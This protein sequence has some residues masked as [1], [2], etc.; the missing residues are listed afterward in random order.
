M[1]RGNKRFPAWWA[2]CA[3]VVAVL[4]LA[5]P[6]VASAGLTSAR[7]T[8]AFVQ[9]LDQ[10]YSSTPHGYWTCPAAQIYTGTQAFC[11]AEVRVGSR[12]HWVQAAPTVTAGGI[13]VQYGYDRA[14]TRRWSRYSAR[15]IAGFNTPGVAAVNSPAYDWAWLA[16]G[17]FYAWTQHRTQFVAGSYDGNAAGLSVLTDFRCRVARSVIQCANALG[18]SMKYVP[19]GPP[20]A[21][22]PPTASKPGSNGRPE[23]CAPGAN[24]GVLHLFA[25][26]IR[27]LASGQAFSDPTLKAKNWCI[28]DLGTD[29]IPVGKLKILKKG[30]DDFGR[31]AKALR[32]DISA[33][34][35][36]SVDK[37]VLGALD[38]A[39]QALQ[40]V[41]DPRQAIVA[42]ANSKRAL[43]KLATEIGKSHPATL[44]QVATAQHVLTQLFTSLTGI[45][46]V[47]S[48]VAAFG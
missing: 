42:I 35:L 15:P 40:I 23:A 16:A 47:E 33:L 1:T 20:P 30:A 38:G 46:D 34:K 13:V 5:A 39:G 28:V 44:A 26:T 17:V 24:T 48:C 45:A 31:A 32:I 18:D 43:E 12:L 8:R 19:D 27:C 4:A 7:A 11:V 9:W 25:V 37:S 10:R 41:R 22:N 36:R 29:I 3:A 6:S 2:A 21:D 14:W